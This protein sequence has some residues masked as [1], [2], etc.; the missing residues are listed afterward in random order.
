MGAMRSVGV[1]L[2]LWVDQY[3]R[4]GQ[5]AV[6]T[7]QEVGA[8]GK[9]AKV[10]LDEMAG[11]LTIVGG[12][13]VAAAG[14]AVMVTAKFD[15]V[16]SEVGAVANATGEELTQ[17]REAAIRAGEETSFSAS[18]AAM[19]EAELAKAGVATADIL[20]GA[21]SGALSLAAAGSLELAD[22]AT[23]T[24]AAMNTFGLSGR[25]VGHIAD[26][27]AAA[28][29]KSAASVEDLGMGMQQ[30]GLVAD[31]VGLS[32]E[33]TVGLLAAF[34]SYGLRGSDGATSL[35]T[36]L[37]RLAAPVG[38]AAELMDQLGIS[39]YD[40]SGGM[41][42]AATIAGQLRTGLGDLSA[43]ERNAALNTIFGA[44]AIRAANLLYTLGEE[45]VREYVDAVNDQGAAADV[46][47]K[48]LDNL[49]GDVDAL[50]GSLETLLIKGGTGA[51]EPLRFLT[52]SANQMV[53]VFSEL[54]G[55]VQGSAVAVTGLTGVAL[56]GAAATI[57]LN[58]GLATMNANLIATGPA[59]TAAAFGIRTAVGALGGLALALAAVAVATEAIE[60]ASGRGD[61]I[62]RLISPQAVN[63]L[64]DRLD[65]V[66]DSLTQ[67]ADRVDAE[68][69]RLVQ[70]GRAPEAMDM[71][72]DAAKRLNKP[73]DELL[74][75]FPAFAA[76]MGS[77][78]EVTEEQAAA[79]GE[80]AAQ[81]I[82]LAG[83][84]GDAANEV[85]GLINKFHEYN[86]LMLNSRSAAR[87]AEQAVDDL[88]DALNASNGSLDITT[89]LGRNAEAAVDDLALAAAEAAQATYDQTGSVE[90][91]KATYDNYIGQLRQ[92][93][94]NSGMAEEEVDALI[95]RVAAMPTY[96]AIDFDVRVGTSG[97]DKLFNLPYNLA[98]AIFRSLSFAQ[99]GIVQHAAG[100]L[101]REAMVATSPM[102]SW[103]EPET[104][105]EA[106]VPRQG[107]YSRS[108]GILSQAAGWYNADV[109]P[110]GTWSTSAAAA[111]TVVV[112]VS[113][114]LGASR[115]VMDAIVAGLQFDVVNV[116]GGDVQARLGQRGRVA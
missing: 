6:R 31:Q 97:L 94:I 88:T 10:D 95:Q 82:R 33:E 68:L 91:A 74:K 25:D 79:A 56:L 71:F 3:K 20:G 83:A 110:R 46:A 24:A 21:L 35:K 73:V 44:D 53:D 103:A 49:A 84:F 78:G 15:K 76:A 51:Q 13:M 102:V 98:N 114:R 4:D 47:R 106:F 60:Q 100:G 116:A 86:D 72:T 105:G 40:S 96:K 99:G 18:E 90:A 28:A 89:E 22:A 113:P 34:S 112:Q 30:V 5:D 59:G 111:P 104:G 27:L 92:I 66:G 12:L 85:D 101:L 11:T 41:V 107:N 109:V 29:N 77:V 26:V 75:Q 50:S 81:N 61:G 2:R 80:A 43:A 64:A 7:N 62:E 63:E 42:D 55:W 115:E 36:A 14:A 17:L 93:L 16:M 38:E 87:D 8:S 67:T 108:M 19:A 69:T 23:I 58:A 48:K 1:R 9:K 32:L 54:P 57:K 70:S 45:G 37:L 65:V 39:L 52:Q